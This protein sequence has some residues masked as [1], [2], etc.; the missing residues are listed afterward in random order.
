MQ[1]RGLIGLLL[2]T[3]L[4]SIGGGFAGTGMYGGSYLKTLLGFGTCIAGYRVVQFS[5]TAEY[6]ISDLLEPGAIVDPTK[7]YVLTV[8]GI[9]LFS[10]GFFLGAEVGLAQQITKVELFE[11]GSSGVLI[12]L[13]LVLFHEEMNKVIL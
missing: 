12:V 2:A 4:V 1:R 9:A 3:V 6:S 10:Y 11:M 7:R 13:G 8:A 5:L